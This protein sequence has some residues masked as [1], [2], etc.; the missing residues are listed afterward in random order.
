MTNEDETPA[1]L[2]ANWFWVYLGNLAGSMGYAFLFYLAIIV[3]AAG[4]PAL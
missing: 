1:Q 2:L 3:E 4:A